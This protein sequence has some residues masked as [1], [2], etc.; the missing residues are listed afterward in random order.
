MAALGQFGPLGLVTKSY[1]VF[2]RDLSLTLTGAQI[3]AEGGNVEASIPTGLLAQ[4]G[5]LC[6]STKPR[7]FSSKDIASDVN[8]EIVG[9]EIRG[10][11][12]HPDSANATIFIDVGSILAE[13]G[14]STRPD[15]IAW[16]EAVQIDLIRN[17]DAE[18]VL[19]NYE[20]CDRSNWRV[21]P[22]TLKGEYTGFLVRPDLHELRHPQ[23]QER[24][25]GGDKAPGS[26]RPE[27]ED[28][29]ITDEITIDDF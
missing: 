25:L 15:V 6:L 4:F 20:M 19:S 27:Q 10:Q 3:N 28:T 9:A 26:P 8:V 7:S 18:T 11:F 24:S 5:P 12:G 1:G 13:A 23:E 29:F 14:L 2:T 22:G 16:S 17:V 21:Y